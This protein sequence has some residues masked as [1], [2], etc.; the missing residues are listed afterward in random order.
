MSSRGVGV[1]GV[2]GDDG[3]GDDGVGEMGWMMMGW[4]M[5]GWGEMRGD[6]CFHIE[7]DIQHISKEKYLKVMLDPQ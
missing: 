7:T 1:V 4:M 2:V 5:M 6:C 3:V